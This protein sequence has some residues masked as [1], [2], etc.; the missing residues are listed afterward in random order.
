MRLTICILLLLPSI[1][2][3]QVSSNEAQRLVTRYNQ[4]VCD[5]HRKGDA[6]LV[7][8]VAGPNESRKLMA[9]IGV[10]TDSGLRLDAKLL[11]VDITR[12]ESPNGTLQIRTHEKWIYRDIKADDGSQVGDT[13]E[14]S[15]EMLYHFVRIEGLWKVDKIEFTNAPKVSRK[16]PPWGGIS[17]RDMHGLPP[18]GEKAK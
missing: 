9:L 11:T 8:P 15:Y 2:Y 13:S 17:V 7:E 6:R 12:I 1:S 16:V 18:A 4:E 14:D 10:R 3:A 5:A